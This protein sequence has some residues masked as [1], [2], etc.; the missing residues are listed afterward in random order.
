MNDNDKLIDI[1]EL[2]VL[3]KAVTGSTSYGLSLENSSDVDVKGIFMHR[4]EDLLGMRIFESDFRLEETHVFHEP[5]DL[6]FHTLDKI[7]KLA[8]MKQNPTI[9]EM[10]FTRDEF[11]QVRDSRMDPIFEIRDTFLTSNAYYSFGGYAREQLVRIKN[12]MN[13]MD[14]DDLEDHLDYVLSNIV[15]SLGDRYDMD[16]LGSV[17]LNDVS[18][19][20][21]GKYLVD[22]DIKLNG[23]FDQSYAIMCELNNTVK[24]YNKQK[25]RNR[26]ATDDKLFKHAM[27]LVRLLKMGIEILRGDGLIVYREHDRSEL[28]DIRLGNMTW[29]ELFAYIGELFVKLDEAYA[30]NVLPNTYDEL[31][32][33]RAYQSVVEATYYR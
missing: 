28:L 1:D 20:N 32:V 29:D 8:S 10:L 18:I 33:R 21:N 27:H 4:K 17:V 3:Y 25:N 5:E 12:A 19:K 31:K 24:T 22:L 26:R 7:L 13:K 2:D 6:E 16:K 15:R 9:L 11:V 23:S 30:S 14:S